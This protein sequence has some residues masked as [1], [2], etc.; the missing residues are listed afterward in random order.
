MGN[1]TLQKLA[2][3]RA[4]REAAKATSG[5][6][7]LAPESALANQQAMYEGQFK[8]MWT[9]REALLSSALAGGHPL[10]TETAEAIDELSMRMMRLR[11]EECLK[12]ATITGSP[13]DEA[14]LFAAEAFG[15]DVETWRAERAPAATQPPA[16][17]ANAPNLVNLHG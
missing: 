1:E 17:D 5:G 6:R 4:I 11:C 14:F 12:L 16:S 15:A 3:K 8:P 13:V 7:I 9:L 2:I 10:T